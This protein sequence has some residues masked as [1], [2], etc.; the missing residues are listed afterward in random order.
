MKYRGT[1]RSLRNKREARSHA[2]VDRIVGK[3]ECKD[4]TDR[5][6]T[7]IAPRGGLSCSLPKAPASLPA[8]GKERT[9]GMNELVVAHRMAESEDRTAR[10]DLVLDRYVP[11]SGKKC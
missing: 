1:K 3:A 4:W 6:G 8:N 11:G 5:F 7:T 10:Q 2:N 9:S